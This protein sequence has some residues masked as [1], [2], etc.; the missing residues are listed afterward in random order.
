MEEH[1]MAENPPEKPGTTPPAAQVADVGVPNPDPIRQL[2]EDLPA[3]DRVQKA[4]K[5]GMLADTAQQE[6]KAKAVAVDESPNASETPSGAA[7][8]AVTGIANDAKRGEEY[9]R[10]KAAARWGTV[11]ADEA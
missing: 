8:K 2:A 10:H 11:P 1:T 3:N 5:D 6:A 9:A 4:Y 7:L